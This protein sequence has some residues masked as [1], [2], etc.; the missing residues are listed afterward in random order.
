MINVPSSSFSSKEARELVNDV[1]I[2]FISDAN[3]GL[4][5]PLLL[6]ATEFSGIVYMMETCKFMLRLKL[7]ERL[8]NEAKNVH[9]KEI[10]DES[11]R[12]NEEDIERCMSRITS[13]HFH[14]RLVHL[15][16]LIIHAF[17]WASFF[18]LELFKFI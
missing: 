10:E 14:Q 4:N 18:I 3:N 16:L 1:S 9:M 6:K 5:L 8:H 15:I 2:V 11:I 12:L 13:I 17:K 7:F